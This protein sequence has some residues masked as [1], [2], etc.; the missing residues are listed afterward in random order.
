MNLSPFMWIGEDRIRWGIEFYNEI[1]QGFT[2]HH[3][4]QQQEEQ[5]ETQWRLLV[6]VVVLLLLQTRR[7]PFTDPIN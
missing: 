1:Y 6:I 3:K 5:E 4:Q 2:R 7:R